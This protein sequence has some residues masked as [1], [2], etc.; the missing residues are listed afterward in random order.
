[1]DSARELV[2]FTAKRDTF[3]ET[4]LYVASFSPSA[5]PTAIVRLTQLGYSH[6]VIMD[7][8]CEKF[9]D[10]F[11]STEEKPRCMVKYLEWQK[12]NIFPN[13]S[14]RVGVSIGYGVAEDDENDDGREEEKKVPAGEFF[15]FVNRD[16][17]TIHGCLYRPANYVPGRRY[18]TL[19]NIYGGPKSQV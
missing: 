16:G 15:E 7:E 19:L 12:G 1:M 3:L 2:Y 6:I 14:E 18:P 10:W 4:H 13:V 9:L 17:V 11:S 8:K 5:D